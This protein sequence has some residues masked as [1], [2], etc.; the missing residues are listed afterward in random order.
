MTTSWPYTFQY[1]IQTS[2]SSCG[3]TKLDLQATECPDCSKQA[4]QGCGLSCNPQSYTLL[5]HWFYPISRLSGMLA[6]APALQ[7]TEGSREL[8]MAGDDT[9]ACSSLSRSTEKIIAAK[10]QCPRGK[11]MPTTFCKASFQDS[12]SIPFGLTQILL[13]LNRVLT[14]PHT[15]TSSLCFCTCQPI[16]RTVEWLCK[17]QAKTSL[18]GQE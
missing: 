7:G 16:P 5:G 14:V 18:L 17:H 8:A 11:D 13:M 6:E 10:P 1:F 3:F 9:P 15:L 12:S 2:I 4:N